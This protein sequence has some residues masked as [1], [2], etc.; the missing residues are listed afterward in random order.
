MIIYLE[1][2]DGCGKTTLGNHLSLTLDLPY[3]HS[4]GKQNDSTINEL[5][6]TILK[7][8]RG[9]IIDRFPPI[10]EFVYSRAMNR[11]P[12]KDFKNLLD[13]DFK[14]IFCI[15]SESDIDK[16]YKP[17]KSLEFMEEVDNKRQSIRE[18]YVSYFDENPPDFVFDWKFD[19]VKELINNLEG[20]LCVE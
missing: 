6:D 19:S 18:L 14:I 20:E 4:G 7:H 11:E 15:T 10:S 8:P 5:I 17:H 1:G 12:H 2:P 3:H 13:M 16:S 9:L